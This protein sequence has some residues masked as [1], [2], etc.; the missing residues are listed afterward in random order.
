MS[1]AASD[2]VG[3]SAPATVDLIVALLR[4]FLGLEDDQ[5]VVYNEKWKI[6]N[7]DRLY[8]VVQALGPQK[9]YGATV[10]TNSV[11]EKLIETVAIPSREVIGVDLYSA[12]Q[13]ALDRKDEVLAALASTSAQ[14]ISERYSLKIARI[15]I[16]FSDASRVVGTRRVTRFH[17]A[18]AVFRTR[19][20]ESAIEFFDNFEDARPPKK[21]I[22]EP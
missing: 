15:P 21:L 20:R 13:E 14:A 6:P 1:A 11:G 12:G 8:I 7:D 9:P 2:R 4:S 19:T 5:A 3:V 22:T 18:F 16:T 17:V 10:E